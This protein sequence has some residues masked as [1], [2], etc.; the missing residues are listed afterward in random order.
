MDQLLNFKRYP[1]TIHFRNRVRDMFLRIWVELLR[2][3]GSIFTRLYCQ[4]FSWSVP[5]HS[6]KKVNEKQRCPYESNYRSNKQYK[7]DQVIFMVRELP[8][9]YL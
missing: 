6:V 8:G 2:W 4:L 3:S 1:D 7:D 5:T 9:A